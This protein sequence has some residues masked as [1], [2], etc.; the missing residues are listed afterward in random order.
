MEASSRESTAEDRLQKQ[1]EWREQD[2]ARWASINSRAKLIEVHRESCTEYGRELFNQYVGAVADGIAARVHAT[3]EDPKLGGPGYAAMPLL[4]EGGDPRRIAAV[5]LTVLLDR[6]TRR[7]SIQGV[8]AAIGSAI[9]SEVIAHHLQGSSAS[10]LRKTM[11]DARTK[12]R[13]KKALLA[14]AERS[15]EAWTRKDERI[16][17][18]LLLE[19]IRADTG[20]VV[21][22]KG[23]D[24][25][26]RAAW[27]V[28]PSPAALKLVASCPPRPRT[29][30]RGPMV[31]EPVPWEGL[32]GGGHLAGDG[33][34]VRH[35]AG[36]GRTDASHLAGR[37][38]TQL[39][40]VNRLQA[41]ELVVDPW[42][43]EL[44]RRAW[45]ANLPGLFPVDRDPVPEPGPFPGG[46]PPDVVQ[47]WRRRAS[48]HHAD[49]R[50]NSHKRLQIERCLQEGEALA[51][52]RIWQAWFY[53]F[54]GRAF[55]VNRSLTHQ[56]PDHQKALISFANA[57]PADVD[58]AD[59]MLK[60]AAGHWGLSRSTWQERRQWG[61]DN[62][63]R[64]V[65]IAEDPLG[66]AGLWRGAKQPWQLLQ[67]AR[68]FALWLQDPSRPCGVPIRLDQT[69]SGCGIIST[70]LRD[71][72][73]AQLCNITGSRPLDLYASVAERVGRALEYDLHTGNSDQR[74]AAAYWLGIGIDRSWMKGPVMF[75]P[76]GASHLGLIESF[77]A[78]L[79]EAKGANLP[80]HDWQQLVYLPA[81]YLGRITK[82]AL[83]VEISS[84]MRLRQWL[85]EVGRLV[86]GQKN[87]PVEWTTPMGWPMRLGD[88]TPRKTA[89]QTLLLGRLASVSFED[90]PPEG[91]LSCRE[92]GP[93]LTANLV[94]SFD[95]ALVHAITCRGAAQGRWILPNHDCF[96]TAPSSASW[97]H[98]ALLSEFRAL[99]AT[100]WLAEIE[101]Q[102]RASSGVSKIPAAPA[103]GDLI[104]GEIGANPY[105]FS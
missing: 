97:L 54:R 60:A 42:M 41:T 83:E 57:P 82:Q 45:D 23:A 90:A 4:R 70:L 44:Q 21:I 38:N 6:F 105:L 95:A 27:R 48:L 31:T 37:I 35:S 47:E 1:R 7:E 51:D 104:E 78:R 50:T 53:D 56:G 65:A 5:A 28:S 58:A 8:A 43:L 62:I 103:R 96:A 71:K 66:N 24:P 18:L 32:V 39:E 67:L 19:A 9:Q 2:R 98:Q 20:L 59:W 85:L 49:L 14:L 100:D 64:L 55:T 92:T 91:E 81:R 34:L 30:A 93:G 16:V 73:T 17:G 79:I 10:L 76:F 68:A 80:W 22:D 52:G 101:E 11:E 74:T 15:G 86:V 61:S 99:Y 12:A 3:L 88:R 40:V 63:D 87:R 77:E 33:H 94:H 69:C 84:T 13:K 102:I 26:K 36:G 89:V 72:P 46:E 25:G 75:T 29:P